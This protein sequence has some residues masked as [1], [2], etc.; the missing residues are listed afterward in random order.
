MK[1]KRTKTSV[2]T[3]STEIDTAFLPS[4]GFSPLSVTVGCILKFIT[5]IAACIGL[6]MF[7]TDAYGIDFEFSTLFAACLIGGTIG[8]ALSFCTLFDIRIRLLSIAVVVSAICLY[9]FFGGGFYDTVSLPF[10]SLY[11]TAIEHISEYGYSGLVG[12]TA[13]IPSYYV[14]TIG[15]ETA[16]YYTAAIFSLLFCAGIIVADSYIP[17][18]IVYACVSIVIFTFNTT[19]TVYGFVL[20]A[21][22]AVAFGVMSSCEKRYRRIGSSVRSDKRKRLVLCSHSGGMGITALI[23][24]LCVFAAPVSLVCGQWHEIPQ[25]NGIMNS[26]RHVLYGN[27]TTQLPQSER[28]TENFHAYSSSQQAR[29][30]GAYP[31]EYENT[32]DMYVFSSTRTNKYM[33]LWVG[34]TY[35]DGEWKLADGADVFPDF[36]PEDITE[37]FFAVLGS[38]SVNEFSY[39]DKYASFGF[40]TEHIGIQTLYSSDTLPTPSVCSVRHGVTDLENSISPH[41]D[42]YF[43]KNGLLIGAAKN[44]R[45]SVVSHVYTRGGVEQAK[46]LDDIIAVF[47]TLLPHITSYLYIP[48]PTKNDFETLIRECEKSCENRGLDIPSDCIIYDLYEISEPKKTDLLSVIE[49]YTY[50]SDRTYTQYT[51]TISDKAFTALAAEIFG[52]FGRD[53]EPNAEN[54]EYLLSCIDDF[55]KKNC[56]YTTS[57]EMTGQIDPVTEFLTETREGCCVQYA[58]AAVMLL[59]YAGIPARYAEG[60]IAT[61][62]KND[63]SP[64]KYISEVK[65]SNAHA[66]VEYYID[67]CGWLVY[68]ATTSY[69][70]APV[71][72]TDT[73]EITTAP[74]FDTTGG[75]DPETSEDDTGVGVITSGTISGLE[76]TSDF[77]SSFDTTDVITDTD[78]TVHV[79]SESLGEGTGAAGGETDGNLTKPLLICV[80]SLLL[81][82]STAALLLV[83]RKK[84]GVRL[85]SELERA[86]RGDISDCEEFVEKYTHYALRL[87]KCCSLIRNGSVLPCDF[88]SECDAVIGKNAV[89]PLVEVYEKLRFGRKA[90]KADAAVVAASVKIL[91]EYVKDNVDMKNKLALIVKGEL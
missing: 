66:W 81:I 15:A 12:F 88:A 6:I 56:V 16:I 17:F 65:D 8:T 61:D 11:D 70:S 40:M 55:F 79:P 71:S 47:Q 27:G 67:G 74:P 48:S 29:Y 19:K 21:S 62:F 57:P 37:L 9:I 34:D 60:Y 83:L 38:P 18:Y 36:V 75:D 58:S 49:Y 89:L 80:I 73:S 24:A 84:H 82:S 32:T 43:N 77:E 5:V 20:V 91:K 90:D 45:Y 85:E 3:F 26:I 28:R 54:T 23:L 76:D 69:S 14:K 72:S 22:C 87:L 35:S 78:D 7:I 39:D 86:A 25:I 46:R 51:K 4:R 64:Y 41:D 2:I 31:F 59:R 53:T 44:A 42:K 63:P 52:N 10:L 50:Y 33:R 1:N 68:E 30:A 13:D